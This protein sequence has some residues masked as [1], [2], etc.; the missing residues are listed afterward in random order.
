MAARHPISFE[1]LQ[2]NY[3]YKIMRKAV[4]REYPWVTDVTIFN[5]DNINEY[6]ILFVD[7]VINPILLQQE[8]EWPI[9]WYVPYNVGQHGMMTGPFLSAFFKVSFRES[10]D[11]VGDIETLMKS[12]HKSPAL[13]DELKIHDSRAW[14]IGVWRVTKDSMKVPEGYEPIYTTYVPTT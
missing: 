8:T 2:N 5:P 14:G 9:M 11:L 13:P 6:N 10:Q 7:L 12:I 4:M 1:E 3:E